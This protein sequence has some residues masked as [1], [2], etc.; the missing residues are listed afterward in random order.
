MEFSRKRYSFLNFKDLLKQTRPS[1]GSQEFFFQKNTSCFL[2]ILFPGTLLSRSNIHNSRPVHLWSFLGSV[3]HFSTSKTS[4]SKRAHP[5]AHKNFS[6]KKTHP[7]FLRFAQWGLWAWETC[8]TS[9]ASF[10]IGAYNLKD[11]SIANSP[12]FYCKLFALKRTHP[13]LGSTSI[14]PMGKTHPACWR[15]FSIQTI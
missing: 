1:M 9:N 13:S 12:I 14:C 4:S 10:F 7:V 15:P 8:N 5:W 2:E 3:T 6:F 11:V